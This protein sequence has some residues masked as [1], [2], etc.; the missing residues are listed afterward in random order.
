MHYKHL[1]I[2]ADFAYSGVGVL[3]DVVP[4][5]AGVVWLLMGSLG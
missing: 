1:K 5:L 2:H 4:T 3:K